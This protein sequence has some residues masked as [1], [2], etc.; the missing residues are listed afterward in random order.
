MLQYSILN[1]T[2]LII[3][4]S[5]SKFYSNERCDNSNSIIIEIMIIKLT[6][7]KKV[8]IFQSFLKNVKGI[9]KD[10]LKILGWG[11]YSL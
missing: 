5:K 11:N 2:I 7:M 9:L 3:T 10:L 1:S 6:I 4:L 8:Y